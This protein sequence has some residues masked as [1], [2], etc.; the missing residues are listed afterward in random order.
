MLN[1]SGNIPAGT[2]TDVRF[3]IS[4]SKCHMPRDEI[5]CLLVLVGV[6]WEL[7]TFVQPE[8]GHE[9]VLPKDK[10]FLSDAGQ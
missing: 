7:R 2:R 9:S 5:T 3:L 1:I 4:D 8:L 10:Y 6:P